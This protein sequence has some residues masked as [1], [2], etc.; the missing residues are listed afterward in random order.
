LIGDTGIASTVDLD[1]HRAEVDL[2]E[3]DLGDDG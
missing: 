1:A 2:D 3:F